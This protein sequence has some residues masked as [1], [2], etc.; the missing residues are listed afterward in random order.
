MFFSLFQGVNLLNIIKDPTL[1]EAD[2]A[3]KELP[4]ISALNNLS[5]SLST[6]NEEQIINYLAK[7]KLE[8][9][10]DLA[11][12][13]TAGNNDAY[14]VL[15][16]TVE[17]YKNSIGLLKQTLV[18]LISLTN[19]QPDL[20]DNKGKELILEL[21]ET[22]SSNF[23]VLESVLLFIRN[24]CI[25]HEEN[26][27]SYVKLGLIAK[28]ASV[29]KTQHREPSVVMVTC[30][31]L[32]VLTFD[33][34]VRVPF[35]QAHEHA[36]MIVTEGNVLK[37]ILDLCKGLQFCLFFFFFFIIAHC[38]SSGRCNGETHSICKRAKYLKIA[39]LLN[40]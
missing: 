3:K 26:R 31:T 13:C 32:Q 20:L 9:D 8:C 1:Y 12:R 19:G 14:S 24:T 16:K 35:G 10:K 11:V 23:E 40:L 38:Y 18:S 27:Q 34:D 2:G 25:R 28:L 4:V 17:K 15:L 39:K 36:R 29:L 30:Q 21:L 6:D 33:D 7:L 22:Y 5:S 37:I